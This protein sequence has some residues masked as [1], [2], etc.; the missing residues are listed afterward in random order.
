MASALTRNNLL[1]TQGWPIEAGPPGDTED[2]IGTIVIPE[3]PENGSLREDRPGL[4]DWKTLTE[5][6][7]Q[8]QRS[9]AIYVD[10]IGRMQ[11]ELHLLA[12][13]IPKRLQALIFAY[14]QRPTPLP[15]CIAAG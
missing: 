3:I 7:E 1:Q 6:F 15:L 2:N 11:E 8:G 5:G 13:S 12:G 10:Y 4:L 14:P 9:I